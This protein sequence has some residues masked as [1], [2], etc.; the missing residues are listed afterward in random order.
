[1]Q[2]KTLN[3]LN[4][5]N[6]KKESISFSPSINIFIGNNAAG[7][8]N[9]LESIYTLSLV[10]SYKAKDK[11]IV[12]SGEQFY[13]LN[14]SV[15]NKTKELSLLLIGSE[16]GKKLFRNGIEIKKQSEFVG[17]INVVLF[18]PD[19]MLMI[20]GGPQERRNFMDLSLL[21]LSSTYVEDYAAF[22]QHLKF[23]NDYLKYAFPKLEEGKE[24]KDDMVDISTTNFYSCNKKIYEARREFVTELER[25]TETKYRILSG[26]DATIRLKYVVNF[27]DSIDFFNK[28]TMDD[29][30]K[31]STQCGCQRDDIEFYKNGLSFETNCSQGE[32]RMLSLSLK[33][34]LAEMLRNKKGESPV[35]LLDDVFSE[36]DKNHQNRLLRMLDRSMQIIITT[37]DIIKI[38]EQALA[39]SKIFMIDHGSIK[40]AVNNG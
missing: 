20:K 21:Q 39:N 16:E 2:I 40:E 26:E 9:I 19:D 35:V 29:I 6:Y 4:F 7:K 5:R 36:L 25:I 38:G 11:D 1:M 13:R 17:G 32:G 8:T 15:L 28:R 31:G 33:L 10:R 22:K 34:A 24:F 37:T 18:S 27:E 14:A 12:K 23:R 3:L 30:R